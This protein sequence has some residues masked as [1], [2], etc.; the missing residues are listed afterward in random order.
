M[1]YSVVITV[2]VCFPQQLEKEVQAQSTYV[3]LWVGREK[4]FCSICRIR[5]M[6]AKKQV[7]KSLGSTCCIKAGYHLVMEKEHC[8]KKLK[9]SPG[10]IV[11]TGDKGP[12][13]A[14]WYPVSCLCHQAMYFALSALKANP[15][16]ETCA[17]YTNAEFRLFMT[18]MQNQTGLHSSRSQMSLTKTSYWNVNNSFLYRKQWVHSVMLLGN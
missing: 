7:P 9:I 17:G 5:N 12:W 15:L 16:Q 6:A 18:Q 14:K 13:A 8:M 4:F 3:A 1:Q 2:P 11:L 10:H